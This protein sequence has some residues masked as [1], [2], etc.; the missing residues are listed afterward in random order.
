MVGL[1]EGHTVYTED[2]VALCPAS[3]SKPLQAG[4]DDGEVPCLL[5]FELGFNSL[6]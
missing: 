5:R 4:G 2:M 1:W 6:M 3:I